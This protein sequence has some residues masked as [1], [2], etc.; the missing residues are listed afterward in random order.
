MADIIKFPTKE[1]RD[2]R[3]LEK[4]FI[5]I[6]TEANASDEMKAY[7]INRMKKVVST[8]FDREFKL[9]FDLQNLSNISSETQEAINKM[10][11]D[12]IENLSK[13]IHAYTN[14]MLFD[15]LLLEIEL[16]KLKNG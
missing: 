3:L 11:N 5:S 1:I 10:I 8:K 4:S 13:Q 7:V 6:L 14:E 16:Y 2:W 12:G 9:S 15:R